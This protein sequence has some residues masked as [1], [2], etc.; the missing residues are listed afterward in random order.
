LPGRKVEIA[1]IFGQADG[2]R[3]AFSWEE[4]GDPGDGVF[5]VDL[6]ELESMFRLIGFEIELAA[7]FGE[8]GWR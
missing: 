1:S 2:R 6:I 5:L 3:Q 4:V 7:I 8:I